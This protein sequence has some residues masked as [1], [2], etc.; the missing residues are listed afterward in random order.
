MVNFILGIYRRLG[1]LLDRAGVDREI[2]LAVLEIKLIQD[3]RRTISGMSSQQG[4]KTNRAFMISLVTFAVFGGLIGLVLLWTESPLTGLTLI[5]S[6]VMVMMG[7]MLV[8]DFTNVL[9]DT[10]D[11]AILLP[12]PVSDKTLLAVRTAHIVTYLGT[13]S[14]ALSLGTMVTGTI[15]FHPL[16]ALI[17]LGTL[18]LSLI[19]VIFVVYLFY[20]LAMKMT[21]LEKFRDII[22]YFQ[23]GMTIFF[24]GAYQL[25]PRLIDVKN[26]KDISI[27]DS[28]WIYIM[29]PSWMAGPVELLTGNGGIPIWI[30][31]GLSLL[32]PIICL[33]FVLKILAPG[34]TQGL[35]NLGNSASGS[36]G[37][38]NEIGHSFFNRWWS[39]I[40]TRDPEERTSFQL[41]WAL[42]SR[43][44]AFKLATYPAAAFVLIIMAV[45][46]FGELDDGD[47]LEAALAE[48]RQDKIYLFILYF[49]CYVGPLALIQMRFS[50]QYQ[51]AW[52]YYVLP[53]TKPGVVISAGLKVVLARF[54]MPIF[55]IVASLVLL[56]WGPTVL[57]DIFL[58]G[59]V[60]LAFSLLIVLLMNPH[61][62]FS[63]PRSAATS[64]QGMSIM[65]GMVV[66][67]C[68]GWL[69]YGLSSLAYGVPLA[70]VVV[71]VIVVLGFRRCRRI[72]WKKAWT[73]LGLE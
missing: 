49:A 68:V 27:E 67:A 31:T 64:P 5:N 42:A 61:F 29:P 26:L 8:G 14:L 18:I 73:S 15:A 28:W 17:Y 46:F 4:K 6:F 23:I 35:A 40:L 51:A 3:Q 45:M 37:G 57:V 24:F 56:V 58:A 66:L 54:S 7:L 20:L 53:L 39:K 59:C 63:T 60:L 19:V 50:D 10:T 2:F 16:F 36:Q 41:L 44:R 25:V 71:L 43:D 32:V 9:V 48:L 33:F 65:L 47:G 12:R 30:L 55:S 22:L 52:S 62:P 1:W 13:L 69:H 38:G 11:N 21:D 72:S 34:F 70:A